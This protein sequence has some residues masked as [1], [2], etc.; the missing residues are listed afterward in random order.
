M[1]RAEL[2][3]RDRPVGEDLEQERLELVVGPVDLVDQ[4]DRRYPSAMIERAQQGSLHEEPTR[5]Q[6]VL[7]DLAA[8]RLDRTEV[9]QLARVVPLVHRL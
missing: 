7:I 1:H 6:L 8:A 2:R 3:H 5:V 9:Q 4:Q